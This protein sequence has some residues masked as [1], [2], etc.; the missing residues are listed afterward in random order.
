MR[1]SHF[2]TVS[3]AIP[4]FITKI[5]TL[6]LS[7]LWTPM[8]YDQAESLMGFSITWCAVREERAQK[9]LN[10]LELSPTGETEEIPESLISSAKLD[11]GWRVI[12]YNEYGCPFLTAE[13][14]GTISKEHDVLV[15]LVEEHVMAS[16]AEFWSGGTRK[17]WISHQGDKGPRGL[18]TDG[19]LPESF[20]SIRSEMETAQRADGG[21]ESDVDYFFE[22]P[23]KVAESIVG[24]KHD[25]ECPHMSEGQFV[26][27][28]RPATKKGLFG[29]LFSR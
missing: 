12:W 10:E 19:R 17:W 28:S 14:L 6:W 16:S 11:T 23:L 3:Q 21:D 18:S 24:F 4:G 15:C 8:I 26:V 29:K 2:S 22:I 1:F 27:L 5:R 13:Q 7:L 20:S 9:L 25:E